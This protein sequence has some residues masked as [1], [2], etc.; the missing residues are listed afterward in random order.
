MSEWREYRLAD[1]CIPKNGI[2]TGPFGSQLHKKDYVDVG[3]PI[4]TV[5]H[6]CNNWITTQNL[7]MVSNSDKERLSK[8]SLKNGDIVF[9]RVGSVDRRA[10]IRTEQEGWLFS[11][12]C[13]RVRLDQT[14][15]NPAFISF[16][17]G[18]DT[19]KEYMRSIAVGATMPSLN[20]Q[21]L[22]DVKILLPPLPE[23]KSIASILS[24]LDDKIELNRRMNETLEAMARAIFKDWFVD[25]GPTRA[26]QEGRAAYLPEHLWSLFPEAID[27]ETGLPMG[28]EILTLGEMGKII[29]GKTPSTKFP[30]YFGG[31]IPFITPSDM[32]G[33]K[34]IHKTSR[35]LTRKG[36]S[37][38]KSS[39]ITAG[40]IA[41]SC[42]GSD[43]GKVVYVV[44]ESV[45]N[46]Q[47]NSVILNEGYS[48]EYL[49]YDLIGRQAELQNLSRG[50]SAVPILNKTHF[51][52]VKSVIPSPP[53]LHQFDVIAKS[54][55][56]KNFAN[57]MESRTLAEMRDR[58][59]P[60]LMSGEIRVKDAEKL[61]EEVM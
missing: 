41:V 3:T 30:E 47:I 21:L 57:E 49:Y 46:Q 28:W 48:N 23:Q 16:Q 24:S 25:F 37:V 55:T 58:L 56:E 31:D 7:P 38:V 53:L 1:V 8:Y 52:Q 15:A 61:V 32:E 14:K 29:T 18:L 50:G 4:I 60:K 45:T 10:L 39:L 12:R 51:S 6:L 27:L 13:L 17:F 33:T 36:L 26:K 2:Q 42:I 54:I 20:T 19:F 9:S 44:K 11:G 40:S 59:L 22:S 34:G 5:E 43:M 35:Y